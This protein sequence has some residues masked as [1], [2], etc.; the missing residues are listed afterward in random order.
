[1]ITTFQFILFSIFVSLFAYY[2]YIKH[3]G[4]KLVWTEQLSLLETDHRQLTMS[5]F[6][7][8]PDAKH[9]NAHYIR[10]GNKVPMGEGLTTYPST[11]G[12]GKSFIHIRQLQNKD[13]SLTPMGKN[14][15]GA[16][17]PTRY[18]YK[19]YTSGETVWR[20]SFERDG[21]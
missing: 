11:M 3:K 16:T 9:S 1:M 10:G 20:S 2:R 17:A 4:E 19:D 7:E 5:S 14:F 21:E 15:A 18:Y 13:G 8:N 6:G 12:V